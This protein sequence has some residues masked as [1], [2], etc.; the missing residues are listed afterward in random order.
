MPSQKIHA[1][2]AHQGIASRRK[3][4]ELVKKGLITI[5]EQVAELGQRVDPEKDQV[6]YQGKP[7]SSPQELRYYLINKPIGYLST[8]Q[9]ELGRQTVL[10]LL[11]PMPERLYPVGRLDQESHGL[12]LLTNDGD[13][14]YL[15]THP[16]F[17]IP[18]TYHVLVSG[19]PSGKAIDHLRRGVRLKEGYTRPAEVSIVG[20]EN[21]NTWLSI[22]I[23]EGRNRQVRRMMERVGYTVRDLIRKEIGPF[24]LEQLG[25]KKY[26]ALTKDQI[27]EFKAYLTAIAQ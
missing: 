22:T 19:R 1:Y 10:D 5:N 26:L 4:E 21:D 7:V 20:H 3:A 8:T 16:K 17:E 13:A 27:V 14:A 15:L 9:D 6:K 2:L 24:Q 11:P 18:K 25:K 12:M 23:H